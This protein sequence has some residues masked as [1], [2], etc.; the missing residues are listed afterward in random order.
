MRMRCR[1]VRIVLIAAVAVMY[2]GDV[3]AH[4][5]S[6]SRSTWWIGAERVSAVFTAP[7]L[8]VT[9]LGEVAI[10]DLPDVFARHLGESVSVSSGRVPCTPT[11]VPLV[12][13][14]EPGFVRAELL[15]SCRDTTALTLEIAP[16][17][18]VAPSHLHMA[19]VRFSGEA[20]RDYLF[21]DSVRKHEMRR[22]A[23]DRPERDR[24]SVV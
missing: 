21:S 22:H 9:R 6:Q 14:A 4:T 17:V 18:G 24:K 13:P 7:V 2:T 5:R 1:T 16:F 20:T 23:V 12:L 8:E 19:D 15:F 11:T 3:S 10:A